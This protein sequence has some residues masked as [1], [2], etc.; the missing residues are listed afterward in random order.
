MKSKKLLALLVSPLLLLTSCVGDDSSTVADSTS[1]SSSSVDTSSSTSSSTDPVE[2]KQ[3]DFYIQTSVNSNKCTDIWAW[4][5]DGSYLLENVINVNEEIVIKDISFYKGSLVLGTTL[6]NVH[7]QW[8]KSDEGVSLELTTDFFTSLTG[9]LLRNAD[10]SSQTA[11]LPFSGKSLV[12]EIAPFY[13]VNDNGTINSY[14]SE[15]SLPVLEKKPTIPELDSFTFYYYREDQ[16]YDKMDTVY[17]W[18][19]DGTKSVATIQPDWKFVNLSLN[20]K[21]RI[22]ATFTI[23]FTTEYA[24]SYNWNIKPNEKVTLTSEYLTGGMIVRTTDGVYKTSDIKVDW[25]KVH[26]DGSDVGTIIYVDKTSY[27]WKSDVEIVY[28][29]GDLYY[30]IYEVQEALQFEEK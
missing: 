7:T 22:F 6:E 21:D 14:Y 25:P 30:S 16:A 27:S 8:D 2:I 9:F 12:G 1:S 5:A 17:F 3:I 24:G 23:D 29:I 4:N 26:T 11:D 15:D 13:V 18:S 20:E 19:F 28:E 10:G